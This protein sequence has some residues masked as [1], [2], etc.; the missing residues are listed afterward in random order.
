M[1]KNVWRR[2]END[3]VTLG[4]GAVGRCHASLDEMQRHC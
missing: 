1:L 2:E 4:I 3:A